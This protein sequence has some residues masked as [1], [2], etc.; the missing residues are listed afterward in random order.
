MKF[1]ATSASANFSALILYTHLPLK[2][3]CLNLRRALRRRYLFLFASELRVVKSRVETVASD[4]LFVIAL[5]DYV[6]VAHN[7]N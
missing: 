1:T 5:L 6:S 2:S 4:K 3:N 7:Q